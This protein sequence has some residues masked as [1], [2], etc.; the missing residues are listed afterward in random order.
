MQKHKGSLI[1]FLGNVGSTVGLAMTSILIPVYLWPL[2]NEILR[3]GISLGQYVISGLTRNPVFSWIS[4][5]AEEM[6][7]PFTR[8]MWLPVEVDTNAHL[9]DSRLVV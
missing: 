1:L 5:F 3:N 7:S 6:K 8:F 9:Q 4:A 2:A